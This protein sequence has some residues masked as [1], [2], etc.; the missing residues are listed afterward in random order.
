[1]E[2]LGINLGYILMQLA[3]F[4]ILMLVL[5]NYLYNPILNAMESRKER[6]AKGLE[7]ARQAAIARDNAEAEAKKILD[8]ARSEAAKLR[9]DAVSGAEDSS[10]EI[11]TAARNEAR[12]ILARANEEAEERRNS[13]L[14]DMRS[15]IASISIAAAQKLVGESL[16]EKRQHALIGD[17]FSKVPAGVSDLS[18]DSAEITSALPL[19]DAEKKSAAKAIKA[20]EISYKV[21]P[22]ILGGL[23]VK[24]GDQVV[25]SSVA[26]QMNGM[27]EALQ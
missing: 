24:I 19:T 4:T 14:A 23:I 13:A 9:S 20:D 15:Q 8:D 16:D 6:I 3:L 10:K 27:R 25:D 21:D 12:D 17:F 2:A 7:D 5:R 26:G 18:G 11:E 1:M 22:N